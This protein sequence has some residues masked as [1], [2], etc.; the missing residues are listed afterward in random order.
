MLLLHYVNFKLS[1]AAWVLPSLL[2]YFSS[3]LVRGKSFYKVIS[4]FS[5]VITKLWNKYAIHIRYVFLCVYIYN[6]KNL[7]SLMKFPIN[8]EKLSPT[9]HPQVIVPITG[10]PVFSLT[11]ENTL[12]TMPSCASAYNSRGGGS[13]DATA[14]PEIFTLF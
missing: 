2:I 11:L 5:W 6:C 10:T 12:N 1:F 8:N 4:L 13:K 9:R 7:M 14:P 3:E